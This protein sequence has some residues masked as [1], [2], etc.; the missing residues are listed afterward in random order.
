[1]RMKQVFKSIGLFLCMKEIN[2]D[3]LFVRSAA[4]ENYFLLDVR[5]P[6]EHELFQIGGINIPLGDLL[7]RLKEVPQDEAIVVYC[8]KGIRS[9]IAIQRLEDLGYS[10]LINLKGGIQAWRK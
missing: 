6:W 1:M 3:D 4:G 2:K 7:K 10:N 9:I 8:E 5:E